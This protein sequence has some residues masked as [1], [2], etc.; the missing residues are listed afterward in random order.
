M[1]L[2]KNN[3]HKSRIK[4]IKAIPVKMPLKKVFKGSNYSMAYRVTIVTRITTEDGIVGEIYNGDEVDDLPDIVSMIED[5]M[6][7]LIKG[8]NIFKVKSIWDKLYPLT[9]DI[10]SDRK[11]A[12]NAL[13]CIDSALYDAIGK[14]LNMPLINLWGGD[15]THLPVMLI[16]GYYTEGKDVDKDKIISDIETYKE[17]EVSACKFKV[18]GRSPEV[19]IERVQIAREAAGDDFIIA[20][21][22]NQGWTRKEALNFAKGVSDLNIR[23][24]EEP[25]RW[26]YDKDAMRDIRYMA[27]IPVTAG[28]SEESASGCIELMNTSSIDVCNF[29]ASWGGGPTAWRRV[30]GAAEALGI[31][32]A[33]HE[34]P[35]IS[36]HLLGATSSGTFL[37]VFHPDRDPL[38]YEIIENRNEF[39]DG[40]YEIPNEPGFGLKL[41]YDVIEKYRID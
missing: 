27:G 17:M 33:H 29:D 20:V 39:I 38:F 16:G 2:A 36:A 10:L 1:N 5:V 9:F 22:A 31:E 30:S 37:E 7:P 32:M 23:W 11:I 19:D 13:S 24:F 12:L 21:D 35:H 18:G 4:D 25:C 41:D 14:S 28:Q 15:R 26:N 3:D 34:E 6:A 8:K 40:Y